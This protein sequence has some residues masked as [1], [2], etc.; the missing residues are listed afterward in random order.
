[1]RKAIALFVALFLVAVGARAN[2]GVFY[3][4][5]NQ[6]IPVTETDI[7]VK[8]EILSINRNGNRVEV[9]VYYEFINPTN[10]AKDLL[11]GF[12][13]ASPYPYEEDGMKGYPLQPHIRD[14]KVV[15][16]GRPVK[17]K[18]A[19]AETG[20]YNG[21]GEWERTSYYVDGKISDLTREECLAAINE[22]DGM[23]YPFDYVYHFDARFKPGLN[24]VKHTYEYDM[25][26]TIDLEYYF[27]YVLTAACRWANGQIDDFTLNLNMG[28]RESF[29][30]EH[31]FF[32]SGKEWTINCS[33]KYDER[34]HYSDSVTMFHMRSGTLTYQKRNFRPKGE[35]RISKPRVSFQVI[36]DWESETV[37][38]DAVMEV[39]GK[40]YVDWSQTVHS[41][42]GF[43]DLQKR[44][45]KNL[46]FAQRGYI[47][48]SEELRNYF[49]ATAWYLPDP[50]YLPDM[51]ALPKEDRAWVNLWIK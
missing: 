12:E 41:T 25:S 48:K 13:A 45:L 39:T 35:L 33:G 1:M 18:V 14:F 23:S 40:M 28:E 22:Y 51:D 34:M 8:K 21:D 50:E 20:R 27:P 37:D 29:N 3:A 19:H 30:L 10:A 31:T 26:E 49:T 43:S 17:Y 24:I 44:I 2:D 47:F 11:V 16:N 7:T 46:P 15:I 4:Q 9:K 6:L 42:A 38:P 36:S 32:A 5:G